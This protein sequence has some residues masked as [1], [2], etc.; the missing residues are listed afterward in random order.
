[1]PRGQ[2]LIMVVLYQFYCKQEQFLLDHMTTYLRWGPAGKPTVFRSPGMKFWQQHQ[3]T[4]YIFLLQ[5]PNLCP[6]ANY[7]TAN[8]KKEGIRFLSFLPH[9]LFG[10]FQ[11]LFAHKQQHTTGLPNGPCRQPN[12]FPPFF[13]F[14][15]MYIAWF[16][17]PQKE[18]AYLLLLLLRHA[19]LDPTGETFIVVEIGR[20][21]VFLKELGN[22]N[23]ECTNWNI[24][25]NF[26][27]IIS[28]TQ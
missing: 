11:S 7:Y 28:T 23:M 22:M 2:Q 12:I 10:N 4:F 14:K 1:M 27:Q 5:D 24:F 6:L 21:L 15:S 19:I 17:H 20:K 25:T 26:C 13:T 3:I 16:D 9:A 8:I 18:A